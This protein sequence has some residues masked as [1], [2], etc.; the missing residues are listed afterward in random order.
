MMGKATDAAINKVSRMS[1]S[2]TAGELS[3]TVGNMNAAFSR[4]FGSAD[5]QIDIGMLTRL[6]KEFTND[7]SKT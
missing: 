6:V 4:S 5:M 2:H 1:I 3:N 7:T